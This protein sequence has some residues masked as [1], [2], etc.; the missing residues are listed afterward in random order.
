MKLLKKPF[1][2]YLEYTK[3]GI[4]LLLL[5]SVVRF[6]LKPVFEIPYAQG[7]HFASVTILLPI[8]MLVYAVMIARNRGSFRDLLG[9]ALALSLSAAL[10]VMLGIALDDFGGID[11]YY[12]DPEH[13]GQ[14]NAWAHMGGHL[15][16][17]FIGALILWGLGSLAYLIAGGSRKKAMA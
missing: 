15:V 16:G 11:T 1:G 8:L 5:V 4:G 17:G 6:L 3:L 2:E 9:V 10:F 12:T 13:G 7:T 14:L